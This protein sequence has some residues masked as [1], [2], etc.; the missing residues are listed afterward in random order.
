MA[1]A[2]GQTSAGIRQPPASITSRLTPSTYH[3]AHPTDARRDRFR[4]GEREFGA[5]SLAV[6]VPQHKQQTVAIAVHFQDVAG[7]VTV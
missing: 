3:P 7:V 2:S 1:A 5:Q 4:F 6:Q